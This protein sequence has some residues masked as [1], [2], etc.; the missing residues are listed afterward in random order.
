MEWMID[1]IVE[2]AQLCFVS[3]KP[4]GR[5]QKKPVDSVLKRLAHDSRVE[6]MDSDTVLCYSDGSASPTG[7]CGAGVSIFLRDPD[8]V[9][10]YGASL[11]RDTNN[12]AELFG[13]GIIFTELIFL[14]ASNTHLKKAV[15]F[16]DS[17]LALRAA[18]SR[19]K[20]LTNCSITR[21]LRVVFQTV[22]KHFSIDRQ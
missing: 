9:V 21:A 16:C 1:R 10:D 12:F 17:K 14:Q 3:I 22:S 18:T 8:R 2:M 7:P 15:V 13:L 11:G 20:P 4:K 5:K 6:R 19:K